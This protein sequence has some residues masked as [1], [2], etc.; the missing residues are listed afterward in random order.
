[1]TKALIGIT[2]DRMYIPPVAYGAG[3]TF[4]LGEDR[5]AACEA[6]QDMVFD[7]GAIPVFLSTGRKFED[8]LDLIKTLDGFIVTGGRDINPKLYGERIMTKYSKFNDDRDD[9]EKS[10]IEYCLKEDLPLLGICRGFQL[11]NVT[12]GGSLYQDLEKS[13]FPP[14]VLNNLE[15]NQASHE[16]EILKDSFLAKLTGEGKVGV[17]SYHHQGIKDLAGDLSTQAKSEE[18]LVEAAIVE[19]KKFALGLQWHPEYM[20]KDNFNGKIVGSF[21]R[22][23]E[24]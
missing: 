8:S 13:D 4:D 1:M 16:I 9:F 20:Y 18:G 6:F 5:V 7:L 11:M 10:L 21:L 22:T 12:L 15:R 14:H 23:C 19:G 17:N 3:R 2:T 24:K